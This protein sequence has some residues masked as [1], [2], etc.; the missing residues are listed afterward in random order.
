MSVTTV[1][2]LVEQR[3]FVLG[4]AKLSAESVSVFTEIAIGSR[5]SQLG[6]RYLTWVLEPS[7]G[8]V[9][10]QNTTTDSDSSFGSVLVS[11][12]DLS[13]Y[14]GCASSYELLGPLIK[15]WADGFKDHSAARFLCA[16]FR[17]YSFEVEEPFKST[18]VDKLFSSDDSGKRE[19][20]DSWV[21][22][23]QRGLQSQL[24]EATMSLVSR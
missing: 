4:S 16:V 13:V 21:T 24:A 2:E 10:V 14:C 1:Q 7:T 22:T 6:L 18:L 3:Q 15:K 17:T 11:S 12:G 8:H 9:R 5:A 23:V 19:I 20:W